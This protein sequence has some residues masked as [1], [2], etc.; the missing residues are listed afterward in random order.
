M[1]PL[2]LIDPARALLALAVATVLLVGACTAPGAGSPLPS[3]A[4]PSAAPSAAPPSTP[5]ASPSAA[6]SPSPSGPPAV[7][8]APR[9]PWTRIAW[10]DAGKVIPLGPTNVT[11]KGWSGGYVALE[12]LGGYDEAGKELPVV[13]RT[14]ASTDGLHWSAPTTLDTAGLIANIAI[15]RIVEG[16]GGLLALGYPYGDTCGGPPVVAAL[17]SSADGATWERLALPK[18]FKG[19]AVRTISGGSAGFI[20]T[21]SRGDGTTEGLWTSSDGR[22][23]ASRPLPKVTSGT[24]ALDGAVSFGGGF[25]VAGSVLGE[26]GCGGAEHI[27]AATWW[28]ADGAAWTRAA[29]PGSLTDAKARLTVRALNDETLMVVQASG[30]GQKRLAWTSG[31][32]LTW[33]AVAAPSEMAELRAAGDGR[34][35]AMLIEPES[36]SGAPTAHEIAA[37]GRVTTLDQSGDGPVVSED[38]PG[39][40][41]TVGPTGIL[42]ASGDGSA[43]WLGVAS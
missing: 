34:H 18:E 1:H 33:T 40:E 36:G 21:G 37:D 29:L 9:G 39:W 7:G 32:G 22:S 10:I 3:G 31:D 41:F 24:L 12:Q 17:W 6:P 14:S 38:G 2:R 13:I 30:D 20:A 11:V 25:V 43:V 35:T 8:V 28:S 26:V 16:P 4:P 15:D 5:A 42:A 23:W 19:N 27:R